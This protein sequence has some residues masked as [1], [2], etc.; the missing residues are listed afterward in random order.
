MGQ[1]HTQA[2]E[3]LQ[4]TVPAEI[5][6]ARQQHVPS[7]AQDLPMQ[8]HIPTLENKYPPGPPQAKL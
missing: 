4:W 2:T 8:I 1:S 7:T 3:V 6:A 5:P